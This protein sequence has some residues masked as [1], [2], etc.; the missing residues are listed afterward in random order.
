ML[1]KTLIMLTYLLAAIAQP[2]SAQDSIEGSWAGTLDI[3]GQM[4]LR[5]L[6]D[7]ERD[8]GGLLTGTLDSPDQN[9]FDIPLENV[10]LLNG[11]FSFSIASIGARYEGRWDEEALGW[12]GLF[13][14]AGQTFPLLLT[15]AVETER[16]EP[17][18]LPAQW[19]I[20]DDEALAALFD[21]RI[22]GRGGAGMVA[23]IVTP[24]GTRVIARSPADNASFNG[25]TVFE[26]G[27][28]T[29]VF[30]ALL[31]ADMALTGEV[32]LDDPVEDYLPDGGT[33]PRRAGAQI[34]LRHLAM[35][36]S[37]LPRLPENMPYGDVD[38]PYADY[39]QA[40]LLDFLASYQLP[41]DIGSEYEYSNFGTGLLGYVLAR[42]AGGDFT[43][44]FEALVRIRILQKLGMKDT[45]ITLSADQQARFAIPHDPYARPT[46]P[47]H[48]PSLGGA[49]ALRS[50]ANDMLIFL[51]AAL[52]PQS[53][54]GPAMALTLSERLG[55]A[56]GPQTA[57][58]WM[59]MHPPSGEI[60]HHGGGTGGFRTH[61]AVQPETGRAVVV[62]T[63]AAIEPSASDMAMHIIAGIPLAPE[64]P[65]PPPPAPVADRQEIVLSVQQL[66]HVTGT[67]QIAP[68][69]VMV[70]AREGDGLTAQLTGQ[71]AFPIFATA[72]LEFYWKVV[73]AQVAFAE[74]EG[75][76]TG[77]ILFQN[78]R[79]I[80]MEKIQ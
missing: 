36:T 28:M 38:D 3:A 66:D 49:G 34:T 25:D 11:A 30:T 2:A 60:L 39:T 73:E 67:Y 80:P 53:P 61:M 35:H 1:R 24:D 27:S 17:V 48:L 16:P 70:V 43:N 18:Q 52:D 63:N 37:G 72:P 69:A 20:P 75:A 31:L 23:G 45:A 77:A 76:V 78:G 44:D 50:S 54:I 62:L 19:D 64:V 56:D 32:S 71:P 12:Q 51:A 68:G 79:E 6:V 58:G 47:W 8:D 74:Q 14:Q 26:I 42:A 29:K 33:M 46:S 22:A 5:V 40:H 7:V 41:R 10:A 59:V 9:A 13:V 57:L 15:A 65:V 55:P 21:T 4:T